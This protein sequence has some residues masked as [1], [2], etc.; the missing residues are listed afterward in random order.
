MSDATD[1]G[2]VLSADGVPLKRSLAKALRREKLRALML[3]APLLIF[4]L[5]TFI[6]PIADMLFRSVENNIVEDTIPKTVVALR[7]WEFSS[8]EA[9]SE[10]VYAALAADLK[11]AVAE[12]THT[13][14]GSRLNYEMTGI[15]SLFRKTGR[16]VAKWDLAT[17]APFKDKFIDIDKDWVT[18]HAGLKS[19]GVIP[20][21][22]FYNDKGELELT[23]GDEVQVAD[24][25][26]EDL[27]STIASSAMQ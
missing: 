11:V 15:S 13:R 22:Q 26:V 5:L 1:T 3:I 20:A 12:K 21:N 7:D 24:G 17:D 19:E 9:P 10:A 23:V 18:V 27:Q 14:L 6:A 25:V 8:G 16:R 4:V 2:P